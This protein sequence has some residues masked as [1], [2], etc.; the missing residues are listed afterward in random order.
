MTDIDE[1]LQRLSVLEVRLNEI[2]S[3]TDEDYEELN[4]RVGEL[5]ADTGE[6]E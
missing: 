1:I 3:R 4:L 2:E 6:V 5:E